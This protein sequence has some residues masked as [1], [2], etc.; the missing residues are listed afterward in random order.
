MEPTIPENS[1]F[2]VSA[3]PYRHS[4]PAVG[5]IVVFKYPHDPR[6]NYVKRIIAT[7]GS[8]VQIADG[9]VLVDDRP[10]PE[11]YL[12]KSEVTSDYSRVMAPLRVPRMSYFV[13]GD[14]RDNSEDSRAWGFLPRDHIIAQF[15]AILF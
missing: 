14:N 2:V 12:D 10:V 9:V 11:A 5:D 13:M 15:E 6:V 4:E 8:M 3:W 1:I 7:G